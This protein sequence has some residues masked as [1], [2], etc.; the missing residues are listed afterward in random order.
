MAIKRNTFMKQLFRIGI[1]LGQISVRLTLYV[2]FALFAV[3]MGGAY[4]VINL[5]NAAA[6][7]WYLTIMVLVIL[8]QIVQMIRRDREKNMRDAFQLEIEN[9]F[10]THQLRGR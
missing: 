9:Y 5:P 6:L 3:P 4:L 8:I 1:D 7:T 10:D 2:V